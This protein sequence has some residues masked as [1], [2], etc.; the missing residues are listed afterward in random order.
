MKIWKIKLKL[1]LLYVGSFLCNVAPLVVLLV[2]K[3]NKYTTTPNA[4]VKLT[5][6]GILI[7]A[8]ILFAVLEKLKL[9]GRLW[10]VGILL[11]IIWLVEPILPDMKQILTYA[12]AGMAA[13]VI[14]FRRA[15]K[16]TKE[17]L[18][19]GKTANAT[20]TIT[21]AQVEEVIKKY[22]GSGRV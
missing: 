3:W 6:G 5:I 19:V 10:C 16:K 18:L 1:A 11:G 2:L 12:L 17:Q 20:A 14:L 7:A 21:A 8:L 15:I 13:D 4:T 22:Y 9:P